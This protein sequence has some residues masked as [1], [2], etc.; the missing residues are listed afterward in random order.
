VTASSP[1]MSYLFGEY[2]LDAARGFLCCAGEERPLRHQ[3][4]QLLLY[5]LERPGVQITKDQLTEAIWNDTSVTDNALVQC[6]TEIRRALNDDP[7]NPR[8]IKTVPRI[9]YRLIAQVEIVYAAPA[10]ART[11]RTAF[12]WSVLR[13][14]S[15]VLI[16]LLVSSLCGDK[17]QAHSSNTTST[18]NAPVTHIL[19]VF[20]LNN[21]TARPHLDWLREGISNMILTSLERGSRSNALGD[22]RIHVVPD[23][24]PA[25]GT[26]TVPAALEIARSVHATEFV[27]G[28]IS[29]SGSQVTIRI[30]VRSGKDGHLITSDSTPLRNLGTAAELAN[31]LSTEIAHQL[32]VRTEAGPTLTDVGTENVEA[33]RYYSLGVEKVKQ[34]QNSQAI[35]LLERLSSLI[36]SLPWPMPVSGTRTPLWTSS[37]R[38][39]IATSNEP[40][41]SLLFCRS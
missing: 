1:A 11:T 32:G 22:D 25:S 37:Q 3:S 40:L 13:I 30:E 28:T 8:F 35:T 27:M 19:A 2:E 21:A 6:I 36:P 4:F 41:N 20:P 12:G 33:Y 38:V 26:L 29:Y 14:A 39:R 23:D 34:F 18:F 7:R 17:S 24:F 5:F 16:A 31:A 10:V 15:L 9:G